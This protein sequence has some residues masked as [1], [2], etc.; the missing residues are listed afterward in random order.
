[1][2]NIKLIETS[3]T[4]IPLDNGTHFGKMKPKKAN[5]ELNIPILCDRV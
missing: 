1:M 2:A 4:K 5:N 3:L